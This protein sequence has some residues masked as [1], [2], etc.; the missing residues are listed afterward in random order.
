MD[1]LLAG[2]VQHILGKGPEPVSEIIPELS[3]H[4]G[5]V[6]L[7]KPGDA[8]K[9]VRA[10]MGELRR[11]AQAELNAKADEL[12]AEIKAEKETAAKGD[13]DLKTEL[14]KGT[15]REQLAEMRAAADLAHEVIAIRED[16][17]DTVQDRLDLIAK[18]W[19]RLDSQVKMTMD[20]IQSSFLIYLQAYCGGDRSVYK[21]NPD[22]PVRAL[23]ALIASERMLRERLQDDALVDE[24]MVE[25][26]TFPTPDNYQSL[27]WHFITDRD[28]REQFNNTLPTINSKES[29]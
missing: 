10:R 16:E 21:L 5:Q 9:R 13:F 27:L 24:L 14:D 29:K 1:N 17:L 22:R 20:N 26:T 28:K 25:L 19:H 12:R 6:A 2:A 8:Q 7:G 3:N 11:E 4:S 23:K 15:S 18:N